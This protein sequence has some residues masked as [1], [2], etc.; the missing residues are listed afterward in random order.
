M[1]PLSKRSCGVFT[2]IG[3]QF[4][5]AEPWGMVKVKAERLKIY[6]YMCVYI[7]LVAFLS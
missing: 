7:Y 3:Q 2:Y 4:A 6:I 5:L 1:L